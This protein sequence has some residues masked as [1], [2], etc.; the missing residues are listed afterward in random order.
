MDG[1]GAGTG[2]W[3]R[4]RTTA[5]AALVS[6]TPDAVPVEDGEPPIDLADQAAPLP[7][8]RSRRLPLQKHAT[9][10][11]P[12]VTGRRGPPSASLTPAVM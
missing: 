2:K 9:Q 10:R 4:P 1:P 5:A 7:R 6:G 8:A 12:D 3:S 11:C